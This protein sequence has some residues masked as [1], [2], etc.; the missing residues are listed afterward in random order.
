MR[1]ADGLSTVLYGRLR[2]PQTV[3]NRVGIHS[4]PAL[5]G[6][7]LRTAGTVAAAGASIHGRGHSPTSNLREARYEPAAMIWRPLRPA[8]FIPPSLNDRQRTAGRIGLGASTEALRL[9]VH[10]AARA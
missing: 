3:A 6:F 5:C 7:P 2:N 9:S 10:C 1:S 4:A 8:G